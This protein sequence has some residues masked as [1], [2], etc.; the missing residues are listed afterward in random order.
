M[1]IF[2]PK[3]KLEFTEDT[4]WVVNKQDKVANKVRRNTV[5]EKNP[6]NK[7]APL[8]PSAN[9]RPEPIKPLMT[10][11]RKPQLLLNIDEVVDEDKDDNDNNNAVTP[12][13]I[14]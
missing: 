6:N 10:K 11:F 13:Y 1:A 5:I 7:D 8:K 4:E 14:T 3:D 12:S 9:P 2:T